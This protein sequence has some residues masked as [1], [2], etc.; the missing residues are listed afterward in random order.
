MPGAWLR[1]IVWSIVARRALPARKNQART[2]GQ[3]A[4]KEALKID[5]AG[6]NIAYA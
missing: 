4:S 6:E 5:R 2:L 3:P 1:A